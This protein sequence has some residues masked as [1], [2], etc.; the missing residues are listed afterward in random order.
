[1]VDKKIS[2]LSE[3]D[4][5][6]DTDFLVIANSYNEKVSGLNLYKNNLKFIGVLN[7]DGGASQLNGM[8][9]LDFYI[10][11]EEATILGVTLR[12]GSYVIANTN[13]TSAPTNLNNF[14][15]LIDSR[16]V[17]NEIDLTAKHFSNK[18]VLPSTASSVLSDAKSGDRFICGNSGSYLGTELGIGDVIECKVNVSGQPS[19]L[20]DFE[21]YPHTDNVVYKSDLI[22]TLDSTS[23]TEAPT[24]NAVK[25]LEDKKLDI[26]AFEIF[27]GLPGLPVSDP[28]LGFLANTSLASIDGNGKCSSLLDPMNGISLSQSDDSLKPTLMLN[29]TINKEYLRFNQN[30]IS[31]ENFDA[32]GLGGPNGNTG[33]FVIVCNTDNVQNQNQF[34]WVKGTPGNYDY[35]KRYGVHLP[36]GDGKIYVDF[37]SASTGR[38]NISGQSNLTGNIEKYIYV[39]NGSNA[40]LFRNGT[41]IGASSGLTS[42]FQPGDYGRFMIGDGT[43]LNL[44]CDMDFYFLLIYNKSFSTDEI[45]KMNIFLDREFPS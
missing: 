43:D 5:I 15:I 30:R 45:Y 34:N 36:W 14:S 39:R 24:A 33:S 19:N 40:E 20:N 18:N 7:P 8:K 22:D 11:D 25:Q 12:A 3:K 4:S 41:S 2:E 44:F 26:S 27:S 6:S 10:V 31:V 17:D 16:S 38:L 35:D 1:M 21:T 42:S 29:N 23:T 37:A 9:L 13:I 28:A 32:S